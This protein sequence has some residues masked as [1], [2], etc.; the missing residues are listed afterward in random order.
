MVEKNEARD[1]EVQVESTYNNKPKP[2]EIQS[3]KVWYIDAQ[4]H[5]AS[6]LSSHFHWIVQFPLLKA[7]DDKFPRPH[8]EQMLKIDRGR[9]CCAGSR[10]RVRIIDNFRRMTLPFSITLAALEERVRPMDL[11][12]VTSA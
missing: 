11:D 10:W 8:D 1:V 3:G 6:F 2:T 4:W 7:L 9:A 5:T 12:C